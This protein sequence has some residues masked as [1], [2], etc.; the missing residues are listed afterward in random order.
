LGVNSIYFCFEGDP[1]NSAA[2]AA[3]SAAE[4]LERFKTKSITPSD[5]PA[6]R[7]EQISR[8][9]SE[10]NA[11]TALNAEHAVSLEAAHRIRNPHWLINAPSRAPSTDACAP[12]LQDGKSAGAAFG[13]KPAL[14]SKT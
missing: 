11:L 4:V 1:M 13:P 14:A 3:L 5:Y 12:P 2:P 8:F 9:N 10:T 6:A 7:L